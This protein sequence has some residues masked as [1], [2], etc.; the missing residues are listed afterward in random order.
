MAMID[1]LKKGVWK[2]NI[3]YLLKL[4]GSTYFEGSNGRARGV[5]G[6]GAIN[7][8]STTYAPH[9]TIVALKPVSTALRTSLKHIFFEEI[10]K[11]YLHLVCEL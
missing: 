5:S 8:S 3:A 2:F 1:V 11:H 10:H 4:N 9:T 7:P 6:A